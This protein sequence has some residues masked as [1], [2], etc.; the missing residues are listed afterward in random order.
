MRKHITS[1]ALALALLGGGV[2][3]VALVAPSI[4]SADDATTTARESPPQWMTDA[5]G[6]LVDDGTLTQAQADVVVSALDAAKPARGPGGPGGGPGLSAAATAIGISADDLRTAVQSGQTIAEV[7]SANG[8]DTQAVIDAIV[9][10]MQSHLAD[11]VS[12]GRIT[13]DQADERAA[14]AADRATALVNGELPTRPGGGA[15]PSA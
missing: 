9:A 7:A 4:A 6:K 12:D 14:N 15:A 3:G 13:Q 8:V 2:A 11:A 5:L 10:D 1:T